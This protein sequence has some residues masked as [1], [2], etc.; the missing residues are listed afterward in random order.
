[1]T[2]QRFGATQSR[3]E[4]N[5]PAK[6]K[7]AASGEG[8]LAG[9]IKQNAAES[10][11]TMT[12]QV[13]EVLDQQVAKGAHIVSNV[14][15]S[16]RRAAK[17]L[18]ADTPQIAGLV[19][20]MADRLEDYSRTLEHQSVTDLYQ[21]ATDFTRRQPAMVFGVAALAGFFTLRTLRSSQMSSAQESMGSRIG[22]QREKSHGS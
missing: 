18:E 14:A 1:M 15:H 2:N 17:E 5:Q 12:A 4:S 9:G 20:G 16:A 8:S 10:A 21:A 3:N 19:R 11:S 22:S 6:P 13:Q 7:S